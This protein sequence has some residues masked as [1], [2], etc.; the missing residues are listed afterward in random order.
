MNNDDDQEGVMDSLLEAL[1]TGSAFS[2]D[3]RR[4]RDRPPRAVGGKH[5]FLSR[6]KIESFFIVLLSILWILSR[7]LTSDF[8]CKF[9]FHTC[10][11]IPW[12]LTIPSTLVCIRQTDASDFRMG[13][14]I[15]AKT[16]ELNWVAAFFAVEMIIE[17]F[18]GAGSNPVAWI[19]DCVVCGDW[20]TL[21]N[22]IVSCNSDVQPSNT[23]IMIYSWLRIFLLTAL[24]NLQT[25]ELLRLLIIC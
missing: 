12:H 14:I 20:Q 25:H 13:K 7:V 5:A 18:R 9:T 16:V 3:Q 19:F 10:H 21:K 23:D 2:R 22:S 15:A 6:V 1:K 8:L 4:K 11:F 17:P 24:T